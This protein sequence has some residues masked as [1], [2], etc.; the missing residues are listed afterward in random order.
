MYT[1]SVTLNATK[2]ANGGTLYAGQFEFAVQ[3]QNGITVATG[4]NDDAG[5]ISFTP[6][7]YTL[8][9][10]GIQNYTVFETSAGGLL[11][12][13]TAHLRQRPLIPT[14]AL[15]SSTPMAH[16]VQLH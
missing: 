6:I 7:N 4:T 9:D 2:Q 16:P 12:T 11:I 1:G 5:N 10:I 13:A 8:A 3:D 14:A 15:S